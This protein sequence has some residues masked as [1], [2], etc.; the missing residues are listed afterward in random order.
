MRKFVSLFAIAF[1]VSL[2]MISCG[3]D[4]VTNPDNGDKDP[5]VNITSPIDGESFVEG[6]TI[7]FNGSGEDHEGEDLPDSMLVWTSDRDDTIGTGTSF[8]NNTL[9]LNTHIITLTGTDGDGRSDSESIT[10]EVTMLPGFV[11]IQA[12]TFTMGS[13][14]DEPDRVDNETQHLVTLTNDFFLSQTEITNQKYADMAQWAYDN[15]YCTATSSSLQDNLDGSSVELLDLDDSTCEISFGGDTF[16]VDSGREEHPVME[17]TWHGAA[18][19]CDWLSMKAG[20]TRAYD[21]SSWESNGHDPYNAERYRLP[22]EAEWEYACRAGTQTPFNTGNCLD[23]GTE[24]NYKGNYP[25]TWCPSGPYEGWTVPVGSY[26]PNSIGLYDMHGNVLEWCNDWNG[27]YSGDETD[28]VGPD[29][30]IYR[31]LRGGCWG[32]S[33]HNC[34]SANRI[35]C[36][37]SG[38]YNIFGFRVCRG[39]ASR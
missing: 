37:P 15:G 25:Y 34:R 11:L 30:G 5:I 17:V 9:A 1:F 10:I 39:S 16:T 2:S 24:A 8:D 23:A 20:L 13:P 32:N 31:V 14:D 21:H 7:T 19:Y 36:T 6:D 38:A 28:P 27:S 33:A 12:S 3:E 26:S 29:T 35:G 18:S 22:T 4:D